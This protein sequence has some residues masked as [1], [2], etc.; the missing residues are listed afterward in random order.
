MTKPIRTSE[1]TPFEK[2]LP[3]YA[4]IYTPSASTEISI[5]IK[6]DI[7]NQMVI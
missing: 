4:H 5:S 1:N 7:S 3:L 6:T 2:F